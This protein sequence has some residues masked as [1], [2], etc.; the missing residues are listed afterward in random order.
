MGSRQRAK[1]KRN[2]MKHT[3]PG[4]QNRRW[5]REN[6][7]TTFE[8]SS[9]QFNNL[10]SKLESSIF[11][12]NGKI[13]RC[14]VLQMCRNPLNFVWIKTEYSLMPKECCYSD[15]AHLFVALCHQSRTSTY[16]L[17]RRSALAVRKRVA[18]SKLVFACQLRFKYS[19]PGLSERRRRHAWYSTA[20]VNRCRSRACNC[21]MTVEQGAVRFVWSVDLHWVFSTKQC[22][23]I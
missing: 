6:V 15:V 3:A 23:L 19:S 18:R 10:L 17:T 8:E 5:Q 12:N 9:K 1:Q 14:V 4:V 20:A 11:P 2:T 22:A 7:L 13:R 21:M 16:N